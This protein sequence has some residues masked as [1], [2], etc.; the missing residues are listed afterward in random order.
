MAYFCQFKYICEC[1]W[2]RFY[3]KIIIIFVDGKSQ[4][5]VHFV[6][7]I[8][9]SCIGEQTGR[10]QNYGR[11]GGQYIHWYEKCDLNIRNTQVHVAI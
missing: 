3:W 9:K 4:H 10:G 7:G 11:R 8:W 6:L 2:K 1:H 5:A